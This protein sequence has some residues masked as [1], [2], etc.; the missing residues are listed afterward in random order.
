M[1]AHA[2]LASL[3]DE[4]RRRL[5]TLLME[6]EK[7][8]DEQALGKHLKKV[9][10][11]DPLRRPAV[12]EMVKIDLERRWKAGRKVAIDGYFKPLP[13]LGT[14]ETVPVDLILAEY[15]VRRQFGAPA[16]LAQ[17]AKRFPNQIEELRGRLAELAE[18]AAAGG[19]ALRP[20]VD[21]QH[22]TE[23][24]PRSGGAPGADLP[25]QFGRYQ[26]RRKLGQGGMGAVYLAFDQ[27]LDREVALKVPQF[28]PGDGAI[29]LERFAREARAAAT[30]QHPN[31]C[32]V[33]DVGEV[34][35]TPF[36][37][38]AFIEGKPLSDLIARNKELPQQGVASLVRKLAIALHEAHKKGVIH[39]DLKPANIMVNERKE[40]VIMDFGLARRLNKDDVRLTGA[41]AILGTPA[42][43]SPE[44]VK[45]ET[46]GP[47]TDVYSLGVILYEL[48][49]GR[50]PFEGPV[51]AVLAAIM[52]EDPP[53]PS[54]LRANIDPALEAICL[55]AMARDIKARYPSMASLAKDLGAYL[56]SGGVALPST[57]AAEAPATRSAA[58]NA[59]TAELSGD[60][61]ATQLL[62]KLVERMDAPAKPEKGSKLPWLVAAGVAAAL[63]FFG[64]IAVVAIVALSRRNGNIMVDVTPTVVVQLPPLKELK[65]PTVVLLILDG[66]TVTKE[67]L[68]GK[69]DL[70]V[71][72]HELRIKRKDGQVEVRRLVVKKDQTVEVS[73]AKPAEAG[74][75]DDT[76]AVELPPVDVAALNGDL[77]PNA[78]GWVRLCNGKDLQ[79]WSVFPSG[80]VG[81]KVENDEMVGS[82]PDS[83]LFSAHNHYQNFQ[84]RFEAKVS[85]GGEGDFLFRSAFSSGF[86]YCYW[87]RLQ[88]SGSEFAGSLIRP[89]ARLGSPAADLIKP[90]T[91]FKVELTADGNHLVVKLNGKVEVDVLDQN[92]SFSWGFLGIRKGGAGA[93]VRLRN[94]EIKELPPLRDKIEPSGKDWVQLFNGKSLDRWTVFPSGTGSWKVE[95]G[96]LIGSGAQS[97]LFASGGE[98]TNFHYR[99][100]A[101]INDGGGSAQHF[102]TPFQAGWPR[103]YW[104]GISG[105]G[106]HDRTGA[107]V[108]PGAT[109]GKKEGFLVKPDIWFVQ[110]VIAR[111]NRLIIKVDGETVVDVLDQDKSFT[112]GRLGLANAGGG[113]VVKFRRVEMKP[114]P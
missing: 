48:L 62:A 95:D 75:P 27:S 80:S 94:L 66:K 7:N 25:R 113:T 58:A 105:T 41:G 65:D 56:K 108:R 99:V 97:H 40:P 9:P 110:E 78:D 44:Q 61:L 28:K 10:A 60:G 43:M 24:T 63:V 55:K 86:P 70:R 34:D 37:T 96:M 57:T 30:I 33:F 54:S 11:S 81:W 77:P 12:L 31:I 47:T 107:V 82:G 45:S 100:V 101:M 2:H 32:P 106:N 114:L 103:G 71:G 18:S 91:W 109:L 49:T 13:E 64:L 14:P 52:T 23:P 76:P 84:L 20:T 51:T 59:R 6:F 68:D 104:A 90:N 111:D 1:T 26:I 39:R 83:V 5:E 74:G 102:R 112:K 46:L 92:K 15:Q 73:E 42:Y 16:D 19:Q 72:D 67:E 88:R 85:E 89:G 29:V 22:T 93:E 79:G 4:Q 8:W 3:S 35:G 36:V 21:L 50:L 53:P 98:Y 87:I 38:M 69:L 17:Y